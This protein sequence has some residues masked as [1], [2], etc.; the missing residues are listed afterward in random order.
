MVNIATVKMAETLYDDYV[1]A[2]LGAVGKKET[3]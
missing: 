2:I 1:S 3:T